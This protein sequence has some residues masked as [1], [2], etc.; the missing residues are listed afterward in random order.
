MMVLG[1]NV[2]GGKIHGRWPGLAVDQ[3]DERND[4]AI[5]TD[6]RHVLCE[7]LQKSFGYADPMPLFPGLKDIKPVGVV[8]A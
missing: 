6:Y 4:L 2:N 8:R 3:L 1:P 7:M 5:T